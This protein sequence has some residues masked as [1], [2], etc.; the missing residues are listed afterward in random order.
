MSDTAPP[1]APE[2]TIDVDLAGRVVA[3]QFPDLAGLPVRKVGAGYDNSV[4]GV[5]PDWVFRFVHK[6]SAVPGSVAEVAVLRSLPTDLPLPVPRPLFVGTPTPELPFP[7]WGG[8]ML[9]GV[10]IAAADLRDDARVPV[11]ETIGR[12]LRRLH[13]PAVTR[14]VLDG[15]A[16]DGV[17]L[18]VDPWKRATPRAK[19]PQARETLARL[20]TRTGRP[21]DCRTLALLDDAESLDEPTGEPTLVHGDLHFRHLLVTG[22]TSPRAS[23]VIDWGDTCLGDPAMDLAIAYMAFTG[24]A[25]QAFLDA[26]GPVDDERATRA[27]VVAIYLSAALAEQAVGDGMADVASEAAHG[28]ARATA[29]GSGGQTS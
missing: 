28:L 29:T 16:A 25:R 26:Y 2:I 24:R 19:A 27:R 12:F 6:A 9:P 21:A 13:S 23:G 11:A 18:P 10:E 22:R 14:I 17:D 8:P 1:W 7:W 5:G 3:E 4:F 20:S 15:A